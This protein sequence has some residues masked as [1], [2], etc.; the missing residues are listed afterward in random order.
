MTFVKI[1]NEDWLSRRTVSVQMGS[2][3]LEKLSQ[4]ELQDIH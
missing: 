3:K 4:E 2:D 1:N